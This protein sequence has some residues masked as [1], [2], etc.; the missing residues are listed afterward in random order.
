MDTRNRTTG[1]TG[2]QTSRRGFLG[3]TSALVLAGAL[4]PVAGSSRAQAQTLT[5]GGRIV[6]GFVGKGVFGPVD[7][8]R[9]GDPVVT[10]LNQGVVFEGLTRL[11]NNGV[12]EYLLA[13]SVEAEDDTAT[14]WIIKIKPGV[15]FHNGKELTAEDV[16][17]SLKKIRE[18]GTVARGYL[19]PISRYE[20]LDPLTVRITLE[21]PRNWFPIALAGGYSGMVP[22]DYDENKPV[23]TGPFSLAA[24]ELS[25]SMT[26]ARFDG[27]HGEPALLDQ[28]VI[29]PFDEPSALLNGLYTGQVDVV[30]GID[31]SL[32]GEID[33]KEEFKL[34]NSATGKCY[35]IHMR[36]DVDPFKENKLRQAM[37][38]VLDR[39]AV[40]NSAYNGYATKAD[41]LYSPF[42]P[43]YDKS[44]VRQRDV[45]KAKALVEEAGLDGLSVELVMQED[46]ATALILAENAKDIG[47]N[48][49]VTQLDPARFLNEEFTERKFHG[50][51]F[52]PPMPFFMTSSLIDGPNPGI[53]T[54]KWADEEYLGIWKAANASHDPAD[55]AAKVKR[56]QEILFERGAWII[57]VFFNE[58]G[59]YRSTLGGFPEFDQ[60]GNGMFRALPTI[61]FVA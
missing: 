45:A 51:D 14:K 37:R 16:I 32:V 40:V 4:G 1:T 43:N 48:V 50:G 23:G 26:L 33:G 36:A 22:T 31:T 18:D 12:L 30:T 25:Q 57:P 6:L 10:L 55:V 19:G 3:M 47:I 15:K 21:A 53:P 59:F 34:Y 54:L 13:Q 29:R 44:L 8:Y 58:L 9:S 41:D 46:V 24:L 49:T 60:S 2:F 28:I 7:P 27:H 39:E 52:Y 38:L 42:D 17:F 20:A 56:L 5:K 35:P 61:G 11:D